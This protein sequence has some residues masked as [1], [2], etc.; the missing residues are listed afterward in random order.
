MK[1]EADRHRYALVTHFLVVSTSSTL[2]DL[3]LQK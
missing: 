3:E 2:N 1:T